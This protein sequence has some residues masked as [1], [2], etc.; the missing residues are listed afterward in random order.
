MSGWTVPA[1]LRART[2]RGAPWLEWLDRLP[3]LVTGLL[4][5]WELRPDG[6]TMHGYCSVVLPVRLAD[7]TAAVLKVAWDADDEGALEHLALTRWAGRGAV[8]LLRADPHRRALLLRRVGPD[9]LADH[10][11]VEAC[12]V[13]AG[14]YQQLH[15]PAGPQFVR[16]S[17]TVA[18]WE[19]QL[20][21]LPRSA[22]LP[23][24]MVDHARSL[25]R[26]FAADGA[27]DGTLVHT[28]L[29]HANVLGRGAEWVAIDP[30]PLSGDPHCEL[31]PML[32]NRFD[33]LAGDVRGGLRR[34]FETLVDGALL[35]EDR[36]R[37]WVIVRVIANAGW[38]IAEATGAG[39]GLEV[40]EQE[41]ITRCI[42]VAKAVQ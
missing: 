23:R 33:E 16:L 24:R 17:G 9:D 7:G 3:A 37:D 34:R 11:D 38:T 21:D 10:W 5:E 4:A 8:E 12:E 1:E 26:A 25:A 30:K 14:L 31:S 40:D 27:T 20:A 6:A 2:R 35:D 13:V 18:R 39:R 15:V 29:H 28:D 41:W 42:T 19:R 36:A 22:P 32:L